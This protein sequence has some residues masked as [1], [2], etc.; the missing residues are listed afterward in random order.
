MTFEE[1]VADRKICPKCKSHLTVKIQ[2]GHPCFGASDMPNPHHEMLAVLA[3]E[4]IGFI[5]FGGCVTGDDFPNRECRECGYRWERR[6]GQPGDIFDL[7]AA[8][9]GLGRNSGEIN[10]IMKEHGDITWYEAIDIYQKHLR[11]SDE[12]QP[13]EISE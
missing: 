12:V 9:A 11:D 10:R 13:G 1:I 4:R 2:Y 3:A 7:A 5:K 6:D 8:E